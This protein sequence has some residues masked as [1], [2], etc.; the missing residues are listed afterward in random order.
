MEIPLTDVQLLYVQLREEIDEAVRE[1][2]GGGHYILGSNVKMLEQ[3][4]AAYCGTAYGIGVASGTDALILSLLAGGVGPGDEVLTTPYTFFATAGAVA[5]V[6]AR[7]VFLDIEPAT[8]TL[9]VED[10]RQK[11]TLRTKAI[12]PVHLFGQMADMENINQ[13][14]REFNLLV[15]EDAC[16]AIGSEQRNQ[17][18]GSH[19]HLGCFSFFPTKNLGGYG[20]GGM[21]VTSD[22][23]LAKRVHLL[24]VH[25]S[26]KKYYHQIIGYNSRL[27]EL[28]AAIIRIKLRHLERWNEERRNLAALYGQLLVV[29]GITLPVE[30]PFNRHVYNL[31][32]IRCPGRDAVVQDLRQKGISTGVYYPLPLHLQEAFSYLDYRPGDLLEAE[33]ASREVLSLPIYPGMTGSMVKHVAEVL[34]AIVS[35][36]S[37]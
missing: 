23:E 2:L 19:G 14:A 13:L 16:Q 33:R 4:I 10:A 29:T 24:R 32:T 28:Q 20:D 17:K 37:N 21:V 35:R 15:I 18:A 7:P 22:A 1:V 12:I 3:E 8:F 34:S 5:R 11:I 31:Y 27:D 6:G 26:N 9:N 25:G 30:I 36:Y